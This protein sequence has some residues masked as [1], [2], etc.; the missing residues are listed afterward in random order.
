MITTYT[1]V[2][3]DL[4]PIAVAAAGLIRSTKAGDEEQEDDGGKRGRPERVGGAGHC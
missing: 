4:S 3:S 1:V 2:C